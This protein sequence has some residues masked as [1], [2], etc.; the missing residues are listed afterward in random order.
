MKTE[1]KTR[2]SQRTPKTPNPY[3]KYDK[4]CVCEICTC[5]RDRCPLVSHIPFQAST[6]YHRD[7]P[8][9]S[10]V[11]ARTCTEPPAAYHQRH[12]NPGLLK[13]TYNSEF[14]PYKV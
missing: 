10:G 9:Y 12:Y 7:Y 8:A 3:S 4:L 6:T 1:A 13:S 2:A 5:G 14:T 11:G